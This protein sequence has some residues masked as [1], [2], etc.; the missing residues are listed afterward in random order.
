MAILD[1]IRRAVLDAAYR[2]TGHAAEQ[3]IAATLDEI[4]VV[5]ATLSGQVIEHFATAFPQPSCLVLGK[6]ALDK[7]I[8]ALWAYDARSGYAVLLTVYRPEWIQ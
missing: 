5:E 7:V 2:V 8:H 6:T 3:M 4:W 1:D